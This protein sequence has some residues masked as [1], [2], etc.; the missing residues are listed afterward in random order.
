MELDSRQTI[1]V[2][3]LVLFLGKYLNKRIPFLHHFN[4]PEPVTGGIIASVVFAA[5]YY[6]F[7]LSIEFSDPSRDI[8]LIV[9]FTSIGLSTELRSII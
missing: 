4:I 5:L 6:I 2:G 7:E 9:F 1:I 8:L 3:V